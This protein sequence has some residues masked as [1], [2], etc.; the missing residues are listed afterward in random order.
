MARIN[1]AKRFEFVYRVVRSNSTVVDGM[2]QI[3]D[4][5]ER[6]APDIDWTPFRNID[7]G[8]DADRLQRWIT[9]EFE[10]SPSPELTGLWFGL[11]TFGIGD[12]TENDLRLHAAPY[13]PD[14]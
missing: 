10:S 1:L 14:D 9:S 3:I 7:F 12:E 2:R 13:H 6:N 11:C 5:C 4:E 8:A